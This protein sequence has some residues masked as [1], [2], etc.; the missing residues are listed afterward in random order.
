MFKIVLFGAD[1]CPDCETQKKMLYKN[2]NI[3]DI[4]YVDFDS[5]EDS[6]QELM[7]KYDIT[8]PPSLLIIKQE[9]NG[10]SKI[11]RHVGIISASK[12]KKFID[13]F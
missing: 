11:F 7:A 8:I 13:N 3:N 10:K 6:D 1:G 12:L 2:F 4:K 9:D 5:N